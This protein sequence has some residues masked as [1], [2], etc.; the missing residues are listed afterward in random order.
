MGFSILEAIYVGATENS[1]R[2]CL[3]NRRCNYILIGTTMFEIIYLLE[4]EQP[5]EASQCQ[6]VFSLIHSHTDLVVDKPH[7]PC[8]QSI[9]EEVKKLNDIVPDEICRVAQLQTRGGIIVLRDT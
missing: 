3:I 4:V 9:I 5:S 8:I 2:N 1:A 7:Q 6:V